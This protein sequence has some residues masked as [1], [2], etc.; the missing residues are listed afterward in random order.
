MWQ[1]TNYLE[2]SN[3]VLIAKQKQKI[4]PAIIDSIDSDSIAAEIGFE[5]GDSIISINGIQPRDLIDYQILISEEILEISVL[6]KNKKIHNITIEKDE[7]L[8]L[9]INFKDALFDSLKECN[10]KCPF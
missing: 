9:G 6:D 8:N 4:N 10:N 3:D 2:N 7:D 5:S 1:E